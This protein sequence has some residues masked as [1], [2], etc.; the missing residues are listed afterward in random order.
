MYLL[1]LTLLVQCYMP[2][3]WKVS[4]IRHYDTRI[5]LLIN[6]AVTITVSA[7]LAIRQKL[8]SVLQYLP[9]CN[10]STVMI[11]KSL[12]NTAW[13]ILAVGTLAG[14]VYYLSLFF[15][16][17][18]ISVNGMGISSFFSQTGLVGSLL[19][20]YLFFD[21]VI[22]FSQLLAIVGILLSI[23]LLTSD[24]QKVKI[25][26][27]ILLVAVCVFNVAVGASNKFYAKY[28]IEDYKTVFLT[29]A[30]LS[31]FVSAGIVIT[32]DIRKTKE[33]LTFKKVPELFCGISLGTANL[34]YSYLDLKCLESLPAAIVVPTLSAGGLVV[35]T[36]LAIFL[37]KEATS[38]RHIF[39]IL[40]SCLFIFLLNA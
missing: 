37:F 29:I 28:A 27:P 40:L 36:L 15:S 2:L 11:E 24:K 33:P 23:L 13:I 1:P 25:R 38:R 20:A 8:F 5:I 3:V 6:Y 17:K 19:I 35:S 16:Q 22:T 7:I 12:P 39:A 31:A 18:N 32:S 4:S 10:V 9:A 34:L 26:S 21:E 14:I 30:F